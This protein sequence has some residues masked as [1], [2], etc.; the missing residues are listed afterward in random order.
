MLR[1]Q[2]GAELAVLVIHLRKLLGRDSLPE[3]NNPA[4][5]R[6]LLR[7]LMD[8][9]EQVGCNVQT[10][11]AAFRTCAP[12]LPRMLKRIYAR[13][14]AMFAAVEAQTRYCH[15]DVRLAA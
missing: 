9:L 4:F 10:R 3:S 11:Q 2:C 6:V 12:L 15:E 1:E 14:N 8:A 7:A 5:P 13:A